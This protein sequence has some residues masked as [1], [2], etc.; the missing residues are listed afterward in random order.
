MFL[1][2]F[3]SVI[4]NVFEYFNYFWVYEDSV[5]MARL[6]IKN[7]GLQ[8]MNIFAKICLGNFSFHKFGFRSFMF[9]YKCNWIGDLVMIR[10][11]RVPKSGLR[12]DVDKDLTSVWYSVFSQSCFP[13]NLL[14]TCQ[15]IT[16]D[17]TNTLW[18]IIT[19]L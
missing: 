9:M 7:E 4:I 19:I 1:L 2:L 16:K 15:L 3:M 5:A 11:S 18:I 6:M 14:S 17:Y 12:Y 10:T 13:K 8:D